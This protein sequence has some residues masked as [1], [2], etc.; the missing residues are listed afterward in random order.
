MDNPALEEFVEEVEEIIEDLEEG[1]L[2]LE[3]QPK[4]RSLIDRI[5]RA[6]HTI[7]GG[8]GMVMETE[9]AEYAHHFEN[10]LDKARNGE[11]ICTPEMAS[12]LLGSIDG[13]RSFLDKIREGGDVDQ[14]LIDK[15]LEQLREFE[16]NAGKTATKPIAEKS[17]EKTKGTDTSQFETTPD[18]KIK[19][20]QSSA[21]EEKKIESVKP[22]EQEDVQ[23]DDEDEGEE[24]AYL[25]HLKFDPEMLRKGSD[26]ILLIKELTELGDLAMIPHLGSLP[27]LKNLDPEEIHLWW[28]AKL[29]T[30][31]PSEEIENILIFFQDDKN[32]VKFEPAE[33]PPEDPGLASH[34]IYDETEEKEQEQNKVDVSEVESNLEPEQKEGEKTK[35]ESELKEVEEP[36]KEI[37]TEPDSSDTEQQSLSIQQSQELTPVKDTKKKTTESKTTQSIRVTVERLDKLQNLVGETVINQARLHLLSDQIMEIDVKLGE[38]LE[39]FVEDN[40]KSVQEL[41]DQILQVRMIPVGSILNNMKRTVRDYATKSKKKIRLEI[42]GGDTELDKTVTEQLQGPLVHLVRNSM[43]HGIEDSETRIKNGKDPTGTIS[44]RASQQEGYVIVEIEDD[45]KGIDAKVI[46]DSAVKKGFINDTDELSEEEIY[47]LLF[48]PGFTTTTEVTDV[49]GR[50]V[51]MD[52]VKRDIEALLGTIEISSELNK[53][54]NT[55]L[56]LPLTLA[57]IEGMMIDVGNQVFTIPLLSVNESLRPVPK[58][59]TKIKDK[60]E[61]VEIRGEYIPL[62]RLYERLKL[63]PRYKEPTEGLVVVVQHANRKQCLFVD[64]IVDQGP[65]VIKSMEENFIQVPGIAGATILGDGRV[66]FILDVASLVN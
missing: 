19:P 47:K 42:E 18:E 32:E 25:L 55:K 56:K 52:T 13:F 28:S 31:H 17:V 37:I 44:L 27:D 45:G 4:K 26:P 2:L 61:L 30:T 38:M 6:M 21:P 20:E 24:I 40:E 46:F 10:L 49:S 63:K 66:S 62:L 16:K 23:W 65:V 15:T 9:L 33:S 29:V 39:Q 58:Q 22:E 35:S 11:I 5:F 60:G 64:E 3:E 50:G 14:E 1:V 34:G 41:Q 43:D 57:I 36:E 7:K 59:I 12:L 51:G 54:T 48:L 8:A 53:G